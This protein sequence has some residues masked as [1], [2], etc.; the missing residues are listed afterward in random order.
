MK[1][2]LLLLASAI[3]LSSCDI[4]QALNLVDCQYEYDSFSDVTFMGMNRSEL[5]SFAGIAKV[6]KFI[7][8]PSSDVMMGLTVHLKVTNPNKGTAAMERLFYTVA[9]DSVEVGE[10]C[11]TEPFE[12]LGGTSADLPL[13]LNVSMNKLLS[14]DNRPIVMNLAKNAIGRSKVPTKI[15][16][17]LR[18]VIR[19]AGIALG[20]PKAIPLTF[21]YGGE[22]EKTEETK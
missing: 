7:K 6:Y 16:V 3:L 2:L 4:K 19:V 21:D 15:T 18:P 1:K 22:E 5:I 8:E 20:V 11:S 9:L 13:K 17:N 10:G 14:T 12:V